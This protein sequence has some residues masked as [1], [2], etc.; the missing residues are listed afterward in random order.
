MDCRADRSGFYKPPAYLR[1]Q[2]KRTGE[3]D[4]EELLWV[5]K[6]QTCTCSIV[7]IYVLDFRE[8]FRLLHWPGSCA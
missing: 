6:I 1:G 2:C 3:E 4:V 8:D 7:F 5:Q